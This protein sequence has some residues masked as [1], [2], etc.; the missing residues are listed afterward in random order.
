MSLSRTARRE[1]ILRAY[2]RTSRPSRW[3]RVWPRRISTWPSCYRSFAASM[4]R[5]T[6][7]GMRWV[8]ASGRLRQP[9]P[10]AITWA[11]YSI[12]SAAHQ[13]RRLPTSRRSSISQTLDPRS[14]SW[15]VP[16]TPRRMPSRPANRLPSLHL[17]TQAMRRLSAARTPTPSGTTG[18]QCRCE[19]CAGKVLRMLG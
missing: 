2:R 7:I 13:M 10:R 9:R 8:S 1:T 6:P 14:R 12:A 18:S 15:R 17:S 11:S 19:M 5:S 16:R 4:R 3:S